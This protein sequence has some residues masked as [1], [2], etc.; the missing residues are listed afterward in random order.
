MTQTAVLPVLNYIAG[1]WIG[2][3]SG[4]T[5]EDRNPARPALS[6]A[7]KWWVLTLGG[8]L[9]LAYVLYVRSN[10]APNPGPNAA[11]IPES[12]G[13]PSAREKKSSRR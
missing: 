2:S 7:F 1:E 13:F 9:G 12:P 10:S 6:V 5:T 8:P 3:S 4:E 11:R